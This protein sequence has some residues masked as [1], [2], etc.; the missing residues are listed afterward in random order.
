MVKFGM[1]L[2]WYAISVQLWDLISSIQNEVIACFE[3]KCDMHLETS[4]GG[5][6]D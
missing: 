3:S 4:V 5:Y 2:N 6:I 1:L